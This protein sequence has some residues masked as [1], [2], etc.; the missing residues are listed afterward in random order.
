MKIWLKVC[1]IY[2]YCYIWPYMC[3]LT[4]ISLES[5]TWE[6]LCREYLS[7]ISNP[8]DTGRNLNVQKTFN[9]RLVSTGKVTD[10]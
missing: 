7:S 2:L 10:R 9:L 1:M 8:V 6:L 4:P 3:E 5:S